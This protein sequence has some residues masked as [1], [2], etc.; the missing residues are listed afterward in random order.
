VS[1]TPIPPRRS[2][3]PWWALLLFPL[4]VGVGWLAGQMPAPAPAV[5][6][7][8]PSGS[9]PPVTAPD[10]GQPSGHASANGSAFAAQSTAAAPAEAEKPTE[11]RPEYSQWTTYADAVEQSRRNGKP[12]LIDFNA[13]WCKPCQ[14]LKREVFEDGPRAQIVQTAVIPVSIVDR[15]QEEGRNPPDTEELQRRYQVNAFP[16]LVVFSPQ[17]GR[18]YTTKGFGNAEE[19]LTWITQA[20]AAVR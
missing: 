20:A 14:R 11:Q 16:T 8:A 5:P 19:T 12:I 13:D 2:L 4:G 18:M 3:S 10:H 1:D 6:T 7:S 17:S 9:Q 15:E